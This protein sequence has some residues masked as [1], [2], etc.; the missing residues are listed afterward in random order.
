M[1]YLQGV[2]KDWHLAKDLERIN[3]YT[4]RGDSREPHQIMKMGGFTPNSSRNDDAYLKNTIYPL[5]IGY[6]RRRFG[7]PVTDLV[8]QETFMDAVKSVIPSPIHRAWWTEYVIWRALE[9]SEKL[10]VGRMVA[11][12]GLKGYTSTTRAVS[13]AKAFSVGNASPG[14]KVG[15]V[16][17]TLIEGGI[18]VP[19]SGKH[20][21]TQLFGEQEIAF[22]GTVP[23]SKI[24]GFR[25][26]TREIGNKFTPDQP[27]FLRKG[28]REQDAEAFKVCYELLSGKPQ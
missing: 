23:W 28:F 13:V 11:Y 6:M 9:D 20:V 1:Q 3:A 25:Q 5:F 21:W 8:D 2:A 22:P 4:F 12:E 19:D 18:V 7:I 24:Y 26:V 17:V 16:Y 15:W 10:H 14:V 27:L